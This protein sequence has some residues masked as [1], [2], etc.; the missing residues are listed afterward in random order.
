M[1]RF[2]T[3]VATFLAVTAGINGTAL[4]EV[5]LP[6]ATDIPILTVTMDD[7]VYEIDRA[8]MQSLGLV[9]IKTKTIW[10]D[11]PQEF[12]GVRMSSLLEAIGVTKGT[13]TLIAANLYQV[14]IDI[15]H[16][17]PDGAIIAMD[18]NGAPMSLRE[19]GPLWLIYDYDSDPK[20]QTE[21]IYSNSIWQLEHIVIAD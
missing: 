11:G 7:V 14:E 15:G 5:K 1:T 6:A 2:L 19:K 18:R 3:I 10:T 20:F 9:T 13:M 12:S 17:T 4:A 8:G 21:V 16:F